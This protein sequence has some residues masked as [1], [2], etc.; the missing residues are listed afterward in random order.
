V[1]TRIG[2]GGKG[3]FCGGHSNAVGLRLYFDSVSRPAKF[4]GAFLSVPT[5]TETATPGVVGLFLPI[6]KPL[7]SSIHTR[8]RYSK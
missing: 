7:R 1:P 6:G 3:N 2:T 8:R 5:P 4:G